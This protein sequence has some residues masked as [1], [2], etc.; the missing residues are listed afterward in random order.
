MSARDELALD[1][2]LADNGNIPEGELRQDWVDAPDR[3]R[4]YA[5]NIA[6]GLI[7]KGYR[8]VD[9]ADEV[10]VDKVARVLTLSDGW[11]SVAH[12]SPRHQAA[13]RKRA[14]AILTVLH[15]PEAEV[16]V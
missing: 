4:P 10:A 16:G 7:T 12:P 6:D 5:Q 3:H 1:I 8:K 9:L 11:L 13:L 14:Q 2:F 15:E